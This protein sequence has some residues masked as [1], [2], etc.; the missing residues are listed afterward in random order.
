VPAIKDVRSQGGRVCPVRTFCGRGGGFF[1]WGCPHF[2]V[3]KTSEFL[4]FMVSAQTRGTS[5]VAKGGGG[6][7]GHTPRGALT[8]FI[9]PF[10]THFKQKFRPKYALKMLTFCKKNCKIA[11]ASEDPPSN[12][13]WLSHFCTYFSFQTLHFCWWGANFFLL[14]GTLAMPLG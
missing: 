4:K 6:N 5:S 13:R 1:R 14:Q 10:K 9:Q 11:A 7:W 8:H 3:Q 2:L 12:P